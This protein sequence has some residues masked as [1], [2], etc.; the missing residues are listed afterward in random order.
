MMMM[1][2]VLQLVVSIS[3]SRQVAGNGAEVGR[4]HAYAKTKQ[5]G[6]KKKKSRSKPKKMEATG[7]NAK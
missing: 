1:L 6:P 5:A 3:Y 2:V 7:T 4:T